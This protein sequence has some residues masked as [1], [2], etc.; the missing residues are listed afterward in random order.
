MDLPH[1]QAC[2]QHLGLV[3]QLQTLGAARLWEERL[4]AP[5]DQAQVAQ[6]LQAALEAHL[7]QHHPA[8]LEVAQDSVHQHHQRQAQFQNLLQVQ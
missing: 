3:Q 6:Q 2:L 8:A 1:H 5:G 4:R 7:A